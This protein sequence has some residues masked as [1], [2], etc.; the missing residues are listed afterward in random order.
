MENWDGKPY[1]SL[2]YEVKKMYGEKIYKIALDANMTCPNRDGTIGTRGCIFCSEGGS[3]DFA[4]SGSS[5][6]E[7]LIKGKQLFHDKKTGNKFI[8]YFQSFTNT[9]APVGRLRVL[10]SEALMEESVV[11]ISIATRPD[12]LDSEVLSLLSEL[13]IMFPDKFIWVELG[14]QTIHASTAAFIRRGYELGVFDNA[15]SELASISIPVIVH[16]ILGLPGEPKEMMLETCSYLNSLPVWG[17]KLQLLHV[18]K[19]TDLAA[20]YEKNASEVLS[21]EEYID[22]VISC[23]EILSPDIVIHR[24]TG[25]GP[26]EQLIAPTWSLNKRNVLNTLHKEMRIRNTYQGKKYRKK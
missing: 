14:L 3:G 23:L 10:F 2:N 18:L 12:C 21:F 5:I 26:K 25:D 13:K 8:A 15:V 22:I 16:C 6:S 24:V 11:G 7:Q 4:A 17:V 20:L 19:N 1:H 9:Y